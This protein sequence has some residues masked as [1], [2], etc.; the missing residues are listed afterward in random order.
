MS[1]INRREALQLIG[2]AAAMPIVSQ[3]ENTIPTTPKGKF[4][5]SL[6]MSTIHGQNLGFMKELETASKAGYRHVEVWMPTMQEYLQ[7]GGTIKDIKVRLN[8]LGLK[9]VNCIGFAQWVV[10]DETVRKQALNQLKEEMEMLAEISCL[11]IAAT[12]KGLTND[13]TITLD[14]IAERYS[15]VLELG[16]PYQVTPLLE[17]WGFQKQFS[18]V[19][20]AAYCLMQS[21][22]ASAKMLLDV[23]HLYKGKSPLETLSFIK[24]ELNPILHMNDYPATL[25]ADVITDAD[26]IY[27]GD[28]VAPIKRILKTLRHHEGSLILSAELFNANYYKQDALTVAKK[29]LEKMKKVS[30]KL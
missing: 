27:P 7:K 8:D 1:T 10:D 15:A 2:A 24:P 16:E 29:A 5:Y 11:R 21:G 23:F 30:E 3:A 28:G 9:A 12:G 6:N 26:R 22:R 19:A 18:T 20:E 13:T 14:T 25:S 17:V 4:I